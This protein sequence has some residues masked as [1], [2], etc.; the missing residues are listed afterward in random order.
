MSNP[1]EYSYRALDQC[2]T[3]LHH[4][5]HLAIMYPRKD[6]KKNPLHCIFQK[7]DGE[8]TDLNEV[9][10]IQAYHDADLARDIVTRRSTTASI[11]LLNG[12]V[13]SWTCKKQ[14]QVAQHS[15]GAELRA[16]H[17]GV[18]KSYFIKKILNSI[19][20]KIYL[21]IPTHEDNAATLNQVSK[22]RIEPLTRPLD[23]IITS[24]HEHLNRGTMKLHY[25]KSNLQ[26]ADFLSKPLQGDELKNK[27]FWSIG[28]RFYPPK[29]S[30][31]WKHLKFSQ[32]PVGTLLTPHH[33]QTSSDDQ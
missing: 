1:N 9:I 29:D 6:F 17:H 32:Y 8:I 25:V 11:H 5:P 31:H 3:Y 2:M 13:I 15:N 12:V 24:L 20:I 10:D 4:H 33:N 23:I 26:L 27:L 16:L 30:D 19:G 14:P 21:P 22:N 18:R 7:G 28:V